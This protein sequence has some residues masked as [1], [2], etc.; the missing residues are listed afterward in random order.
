MR[1]RAGKLWAEQ[2]S[3]DELLPRWDAVLERVVV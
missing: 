3:A 1:P 2:F